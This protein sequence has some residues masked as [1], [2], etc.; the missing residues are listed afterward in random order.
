MRFPESIPSSARVV[1][2]AGIAALVAA[3]AG[4]QPNSNV[5][6]AQASLQQIRANAARADLA[7]I[8]VEEAEKAVAA[9]EAARHDKEDEDRVDHLA[10][11]AQRKVELAN[12][13]ATRK[14][15][16]RDIEAAGRERDQIRLQASQQR[17][18]DAQAQASTLASRNQNLASEAE[19]ARERAAA[20]Q[21][22]LA[23][24]QAK[25]TERGLV[26]TFSDVLF[27]L[28]KA[29]LKPGAMARVAQLAQVMRDYPE[30]NVLIEGFTD[31]SGPDA[32]NQALS[33]RRAMSVRQ[34][35]V[36]AGIDAR[37][38]VARGLSEQYPVASNATAAGRQQNR[39]V[40]VVVSNA[41][42]DLPFRN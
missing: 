38:I 27:D 19:Q 12:A 28:G 6:E 13:V 11:L 36:E 23:A 41:Q 7:R 8:E 35:L 5:R 16:E 15:I 42:G 22:R 2:V 18:Q 33:E 40:E 10:W 29:D 32:L 4:P 20:L 3:C 9:A 25:E 24:M 30:R 39:R 26:V 21:K 34:A 17:A 31:S 14:Q 37:R 1:A